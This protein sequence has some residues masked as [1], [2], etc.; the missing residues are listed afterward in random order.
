M[1]NEIYITLI[2]II[3]N[4]YNYL[5]IKQYL[6]LFKTWCKD[7]E[8]CRIKVLF[9]KARKISRLYRIGNF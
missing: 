3:L 6:V 8:I 1:G 9:I 5:N 2:I 4:F 7:V